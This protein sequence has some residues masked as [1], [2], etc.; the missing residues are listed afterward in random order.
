MVRPLPPSKPKLEEIKEEIN[1]P[2]QGSSDKFVSE[3][4]Q[5]SSEEIDPV[6]NAVMKGLVENDEDPENWSI[7]SVEPLYKWT[8]PVNTLSVK[9]AKGHNVEKM[10][11]K[12]ENKPVDKSEIECMSEVDEDESQERFPE[13]VYN[14]D[15]STAFRVNSHISVTYLGPESWENSLMSK[16]SFPIDH[17]AR[18][19]GVIGD[20][21]KAKILID[22]GAS[23]CFLNKKCY[24]KSTMLQAIPKLKCSGSI[25]VANGADVPPQFVIPL[26]VNIHGH[27][28]EI[29]AIVA[30]LAPTYDIMFGMK[31]LTEIEGK[32][33]A[34]TSR[35]KFRNRS[36]P[37]YPTQNG[38]VKDGAKRLVK[39]IVP[40][41]HELSGWCVMKFMIGKA[42]MTLEIRLVRN[43][44]ILDITNTSGV[45]LQLD[46]ALPLG[47]LD[48]R[49]MGYFAIDHV[50]L[51]QRLGPRYEFKTLQYSEDDTTQDPEERDHV[52]SV[53]HRT[54]KPKQP[55]D[56]YPWLAKDDPR[57]GMDDE[58]ILDTY[59][60]LSKSFLTNKQKKSF[61]DLLK[62]YMP[63]FSL[64]DEI[65]ECPN[66]KAEVEVID[67]SPFFVRPYKISEED[68]PYMDQQM[69]RLVSLGILSKNTTSYTSPVMLISRKL[70][71]DKRIIADFRFLNSRILRR[72]TV[73]PLMDDIRSI[74]GNSGC[75]VFTCVDLKDAYHSIPL[76]EKGKQLCG[77][78]P[79]F[80]SPHYRY[81][82]MPMGLNS[83]PAKWMEYVEVLLEEVRHRRNYIAIMDDLLIHSSKKDHFEMIEDLLKALVKCGLKLSPKKCQFYMRKL[84]YMGNIFTITGEGVT[85]SVKT[86]RVSAI[87]AMPPPQTPKQCK[88]FCGTVNY[89]KEYCQDLQKHLKPIY[90]LTRNGKPWLWTELHEDA[91]NK[92]KEVIQQ[93]PILSCPTST[94]R[95]T[96]FT[97]TSR[98]HVGSCLWQRQKGQNK[99]IGFASKTLPSPCQNYGVTEL[100]IFGMVVSIKSWALWLGK[101]EFDCVVDHK[102]IVSI[103]ESKEAP[104]TN[105]IK[106][107]LEM[108]T[109]F[110]A[111]YFYLKGKHMVISDFLSRVAWER[112]PDWEI[113]AVGFD[114]KT[115]LLKHVN[116]DD[117]DLNVMTRHAAKEQGTSVPEVHGADKP[118][119]PALKPESQHKS[120]LPQVQA[121]RRAPNP[122]L[123]EIKKKYLER[124]W[125]NPGIQASRKLVQRSIQQL[126][127]QAR[128]REMKSTDPAQNQETPIQHDQQELTSPLHNSPV[129]SPGREPEAK[130][131][132]PP[133]SSQPRPMQPVP[134]FKAVEKAWIREIP[135]AVLD[136]RTELGIQDVE[137]M[138]RPPRMED[139]EEVPHL[140]DQVEDGPVISRFM[141]KQVDL[142]KV[143]QTIKRKVLKQIHLPILLRDM[144][145]AY[146][147]SPYFRDIYLLLQGNISPVSRRRASK[148]HAMAYNYLLVDQLLYKLE[149]DATGEIVPKLCIPQSKIDQVLHQFH[150]TM[151]GGHQ[152]IV[153]TMLSIRQRYFSPGLVERI[154]AYIIG[155]HVCQ[156]HK[157]AHPD[158]RPFQKRPVMGVDSM[159]RLS[160]DIKHMPHSGFYKY[161]LVLV[162]EVTGF[163]NCIPI[164]NA[165]A[166]D[167]CKA[168]MKF[169]LPI[170]G[171][172][173]HIICDQDPAFINSLMSALFTQLQIKVIVVS[174]TNHKSLLAEHGIKSLA[175]I[176]AKQLVDKGTNWPD[177]AGVVQLA[178]NA[179]SSPNLDGLSPYQMVFGHLANIAPTLVINPEVKVTMSF[180]DYYR[181][182]LRT[183]QCLKQ[184]LAEYREKRTDNWN[185]E[186]VLHSFQ[187][188]DL[189]YCH[190]PANA[191]HHPG[192]RKMQC[193]HVG[194]LVIYRA[195]SENQFFLMS[196][197]GIIYPHLIE[198][199]RLK[200]AH[201]YTT[202]GA[203]GTLAKLLMVIRKGMTSG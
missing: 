28:F 85:M 174:P 63:A 141:P 7:L 113:E 181:K 198:Q 8:N 194:P 60:D 152:G 65:G 37:V 164:R 96:L 132:W 30:D 10:Y 87:Q 90:E 184:K 149:S 40:F 50:D 83:S 32:I 1:E 42:L 79:Y 2:E 190:L 145:A 91:F 69:N 144:Q 71:K 39:V 12:M 15:T 173:T 189:V 64:R 202:D 45:A 53:Q 124:K 52:Y 148:V 18:T 159:S 49:S 192:T 31:G 82:V 98:Q 122:I 27:R 22:S 157:K 197:D 29:Y 55:K 95:F 44:A 117:M 88:R 43:Q 200:P 20:G 183:L 196:L 47:I 41:R 146:L 105:R 142:E 158:N 131:K 177:Y 75:E 126:R 175:T 13:V 86:N 171:P 17:M 118:L 92:V 179:S 193:P 150:S 34:V 59:I 11:Q 4:E 110:S 68:K 172:P 46:T 5:G 93:P 116:S 33:C 115:V 23:R 109:G 56:K 133:T 188:G 107:F 127:D 76:T 6:V 191:L 66:M 134:N 62:S 187:V 168:L 137:E 81:E 121:Q 186:K 130:P 14:V 21:L 162:C 102:A 203:V 147:G 114:P 97:D 135:Q 9:Q 100:E 169:H 54:R 161:L 185:K 176:I 48:A 24:D 140:G 166:E 67:D 104:A 99:L 112:Q 19:E 138:L 25:E 120:K 36:L 155:C 80:G 163:I 103:M 84:V 74:L 106:K 151:I 111:Q 78:M 153:K 180:E 38:T 136:Q 73:M 129:R 170:L 160:M 201:I 72:N 51:Q 61:M 128:K 165:A 139:L 108:L 156:M 119:D 26:V 35:V 195:V 70:T 77:I 89:L 125:E 123:E 101:N 143:L 167:V 182:L 154:R 3:P 58:E 57:R 178:H 94:G 199:T 16:R